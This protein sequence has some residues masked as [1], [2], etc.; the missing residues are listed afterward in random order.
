MRKLVTI[1]F[2]V[3]AIIITGCSSDSNAQEISKEEAEQVIIDKRSRECC[4]KAEIIDTTS[5][6]DKYIIQWEI[7]RLDETGKD[8]VNKKTGKLKMI[9]RREEV[10]NGNNPKTTN[11]SH[12]RSVI[13]FCRFCK[14]NMKSQ[15]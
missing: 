4:G 9:V 1:L 14:I 11:K 2:F 12:I 13:T 15:P 5:E 3:L 10:V 7:E 8:S 6:S